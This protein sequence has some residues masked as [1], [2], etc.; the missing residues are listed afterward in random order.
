MARGDVSDHVL[1]LNRG[2][3][4]RTIFHKDADARV[5]PPARRGQGQRVRPAARR[6]ATEGSVG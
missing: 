4:R 1:V 3:A 2:N 5:S 6:D